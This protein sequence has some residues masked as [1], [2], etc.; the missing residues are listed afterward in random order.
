MR[1]IQVNADWGPNLT[2]LPIIKS[3]EL[4]ILR[5]LE[6]WGQHH[7]QYSNKQLNSSWRLAEEVWGHFTW[8]S[9]H[10]PTQTTSN[11]LKNNSPETYR[12]RT[13]GDV[14][15]WLP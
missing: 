13:S 12:N 6:F 9:G 3:V 11:P 10:P 4:A 14:F 5:G 8:G 1:L 15:C 2:G 7:F